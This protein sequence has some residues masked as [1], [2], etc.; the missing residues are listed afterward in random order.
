MFGLT[1]QPHCDIERFSR[2]CHRLVTISGLSKE[3]KRSP[4]TELHSSTGRDPRYKNHPLIPGGL[5]DALP[6]AI[7]L[8]QVAYT[9]L[10][11]AIRALQSSMDGDR[12]L[13]LVF[14]TLG[15]HV[16]WLS[17]NVALA[18]LPF[19]PL[20]NRA[21]APK[22]NRNT[23]GRHSYHHAPAPFFSSL[24]K[25]LQLLAS[26]PSP[27]A[28]TAVFNLSEENAKAFNAY[29]ESLW[30]DKILM[31]RFIQQRGIETWRAEQLRASWEGACLTTR[32]IEKWAI[33]VRS[34]S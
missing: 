1:M 30:E 29:A 18:A 19:S 5:S 8:D 17:N 3:Q 2:V 26:G 12:S 4:T 11:P 22:N 7:S 20:L 10:E 9:L 27:L 14:T 32:L 21:H 6:L 25:I 16:P 23:L 31:R 15:E 33:V 28:I 24:S 34:C 13:T